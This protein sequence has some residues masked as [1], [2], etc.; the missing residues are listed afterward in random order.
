MMTDNHDFQKF[1]ENDQIILPILKQKEKYKVQ[2]IYTQINRDQENK[3]QFKKF[4]FN[5]N[6]NAYFY[7]A[8]TVKFPLTIL[9]LQK[10]NELKNKGIHRK[11]TINFGTRF[12]GQTETISEPQ[13]E[14][15]KPTIENYI[16]QILLMSDNS[17]Y[18]R[19]YEFLGQDYIN[20]E[21]HK[22]GYN[23][24]QIHHRLEVF[25]SDEENAATNPVK[26]LDDK[27][28][29]IYSEPLKISKFPFKKRND[30]V[31]KAYYKGGKLIDEPMD[32]SNKNKMPLSEFHLMVQN[33]IFPSDK[34]F[35]IT[36]DDRNV[37]L[38]YMS[39]FPSESRFPTYGENEHDAIAKF[40][41]YG[42]EKGKKPNHIRIF[43]KVGD[44]YGQLTD[45]V[46]FVDFEKNVEFLLSAT[47]YCNE[48][49]TLNDDKYDYET[50]GFPFM[51]RLG[52]IIYEYEAS[53]TK[54]YRPDLSEFKFDY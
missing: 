8:S 2:I 25:L 43:N 26:F 32:F 7:P 12:S 44:A 36:S 52:E 17:S 28:N 22:K 13:A 46:Y 42:A 40:L 5:L 23:Q 21:I 19:L 10:L 24:T 54:Q 53:R 31:G 16:K 41:F 20:T 38:K 51:K 30:Y 37:L 29:M 18:N 47:I 35:N 15:G 4:E 48:D 14:N 45:T 34:S 11:T 49:E 27:G 1:L 50:I 6:D 33:L 9:A 3:P 39:M